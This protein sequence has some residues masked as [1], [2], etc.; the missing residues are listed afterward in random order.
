MELCGDIR[1]ND[2]LNADTCRFFFSLLQF[3]ISTWLE[4]YDGLN[5]LKKLGHCSSLLLGYGRVLLL[6]H[7]QSAD[8]QLELDLDLGLCDVS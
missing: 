1:A 2:I 6:D 8:G 5:H 4:E 3:Y 7:T